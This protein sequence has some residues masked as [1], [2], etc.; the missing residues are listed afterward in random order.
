MKNIFEKCKI[1]NYFF[2]SIPINIKYDLYY[3]LFDNLDKEN[4]FIRLDLETA[5]KINANG[6]Y[7]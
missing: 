2:D 4:Y 7:I 3:Y 5:L 6:E 1:T